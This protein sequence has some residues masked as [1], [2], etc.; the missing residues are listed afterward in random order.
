MTLKPLFARGLTFTIRTGKT[1]SELLTTQI[2]PALEKALEEMSLKLPSTVQIT[3]L[4]T[5]PFPK[6]SDGQEPK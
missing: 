1:Y 6:T 3:L 5:E 4:V 2:C